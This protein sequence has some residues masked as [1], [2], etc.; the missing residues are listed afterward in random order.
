MMRPINIK[1]I[2]ET[3]KG[4]IFKNTKNLRN[5][6]VWIEE[7]LPKKIQEE[8]E[9][10]VAKIKEAWQ[11]GRKAFIRKVWTLNE[12]GHKKTSKEN[13]EDVKTKKGGKRQATTKV[14]QRHRQIFSRNESRLER[15]SNTN[16]RQDELEKTH[17]R[18]KGSRNN[19]SNTNLD[20]SNAGR[21]AQGLTK[22]TIKKYKTVLPMLSGF[23]SLTKSEEEDIVNRETVWPT[24]RS[25]KRNTV[26]CLEIAGG[27][28]KPVKPNK[29]AKRKH[30]P[31]K[32]RR[33][34]IAKGR[35]KIREG[36]PLPKPQPQKNFTLNKVRESKNYSQM[37]KNSKPKTVQRPRPINQDLDIKMMLQNMMDVITQVNIIFD[38]LEARNTGDIPNRYN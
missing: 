1:E 30:H 36:K 25:K 6:N 21:E 17:S 22:K 5:T 37:V 16:K 7:D 15:G 24:H 31:A 4:P 18:H 33:C 28:E 11:K 2:K 34:K 35:Q 26:K 29:T 27:A 3:T 9:E 38:T 13:M 8:R 14:E 23:E 20:S 32:Y 12:N 19:M 10:L